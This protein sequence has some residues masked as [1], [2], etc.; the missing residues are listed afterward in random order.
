MLPANFSS[1]T[2]EWATPQDVFDAINEEYVDW[3]EET[4]ITLIA[5]SIDNARTSSKV[6]P[7]V[8]GK[9]WEFQVLLDANQDFKRAMN[10]ASVPHL[11]IVKNNEILYTHSGYTPGFEIELYN[12]IK[13]LNSQ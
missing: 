12:K 2:S 11:F 8:N 10:I 4:G 7:M 9:N 6:R 3:Q 1:E 5:V 13:E